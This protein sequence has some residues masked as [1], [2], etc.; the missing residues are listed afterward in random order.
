MLWGKRDLVEALDVPRL[1]PAP[2]ESPERLETGTQNH[3][4]IVGAAAAVDFLASLSNTES[5][6][7]RAGLRETY[8]ALHARGDAL[9]AKL[10]NSLREIPGLK[11][12]GPPPGTPRTPTLSF[13]LRGLTTDEV[14]VALAK[15]G[16]FVSNG[17]FYAATIIDRYGLRPE[18]LVRV[19]CSCYTREDEVDRLISGVRALA[20]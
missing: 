5:A 15:R 2:Q 20:G 17:D 19:G 11:L 12:Y 8:A 6:T 13:T 18:G 9:L 1:D 7:R 16:I 14:A 10:W 3:E 4:G